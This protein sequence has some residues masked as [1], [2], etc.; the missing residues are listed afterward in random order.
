MRHVIVSRDTEAEAESTERPQTWDRSCGTGDAVSRETV[1]R[2]D[3]VADAEVEQ[4]L[5]LRV[6]VEAVAVAA[7]AAVVVRVKERI[8]VVVFGVGLVVWYERFEC[9]CTLTGKR[10]KA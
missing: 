5:A 8:F 9:V 6:T 1:R 7:R 3:A 2:L 4:G 10:M